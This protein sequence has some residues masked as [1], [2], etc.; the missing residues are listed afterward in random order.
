[1]IALL[2]PALALLLLSS[3]PVPQ[4]D[5]NPP[6]DECRCIRWMCP[7]EGECV[8]VKVEFCPLKRGRK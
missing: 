5:P 6:A 1:M 7:A 4:L 8:C 3:E 2:A